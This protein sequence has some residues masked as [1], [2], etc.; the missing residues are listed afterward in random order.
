MRFIDHINCKGAFERGETHEVFRMGELT[1]AA[2]KIAE[3][4]GLGVM[5]TSQGVYRIIKTCGFG[6]YEDSFA[7]LTEVD[8]F[9]KCID[10]QR[11]S[12]DHA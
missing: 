1:R 11:H 2:S 7:S 10:S 12:I 5:R 8:N 4:N 3:A 9:F 6:V